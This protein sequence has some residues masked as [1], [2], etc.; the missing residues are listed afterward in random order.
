M[1]FTKWLILAVITLLIFAVSACQKD[2]VQ[3]EQK[4]KTSSEKSTA[5]HESQPKATSNEWEEPNDETAVKS[6]DTQNG[7]VQKQAEKAP[8]VAS[9]TQQTKK[10][11]KATA[12]A[13]TMP[14]KETP[15][16]AAQPTASA[17]VQVVG[18]NG[19]AILPAV[20]VSIVKG[21]TVLTMTQRILKNKKIPISVRGSGSTAYVEGINNQFEFDHGPTSGWIVQVNGQNINRSS[22][23][24]AVKKGDKIIWKYVTEASGGNG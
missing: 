19:Q 17:V 5:I 2:T 24:I 8:T 1:R 3:P 7:N 12:S 4:S 22:G 15:S 23:V 6:A 9:S 20:N 11:E 18:Y 16:P 21:D 13:K 10:S 14:K